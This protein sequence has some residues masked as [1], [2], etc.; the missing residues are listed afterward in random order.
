MANN[1]PEEIYA[2]VDEMIE[3]LQITSRKGKGD[4]LITCNAEYLLARKGD[5]PTI[6]DKLKCVDFGGY[7]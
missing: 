5:V 1:K 7:I 2:T 4:Y 3:M 6:N